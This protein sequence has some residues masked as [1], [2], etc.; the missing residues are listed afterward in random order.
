MAS[1]EVACPAGCGATAREFPGVLNEYDVH[2]QDHPEHRNVYCPDCSID[3][4]P[5][6]V[7]R[8]VEYWQAQGLDLVAIR[9][10]IEVM[11]MKSRWT[12]R[13]IISEKTG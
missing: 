3:G 4:G 2:L 5:P 10:K 6:D 11:K 13:E 7:A 1:K 12:L 9:R 8:F